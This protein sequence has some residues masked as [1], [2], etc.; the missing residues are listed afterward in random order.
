MHG[1]LH[2][3]QLFRP[4]GQDGFECR[5]TT[6]SFVSVMCLAV[7]N[8]GAL[9]AWLSVTCRSLLKEK[10]RNMKILKSVRVHKDNLEKLKTLQC[11]QSVST[12]EDGRQVVCR[13][14]D[15]KTRGSLIARTDD[16]LV[17]FETGEWQRYGSEAYSTLVWSP[18]KI[19]K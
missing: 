17:E 19:A 4:S 2:R 5:K 10:R 3:F 9:A 16:W 13:F 18:S 14:K 1:S 6:S 15:N 11:L 8:V 7:L 12:S